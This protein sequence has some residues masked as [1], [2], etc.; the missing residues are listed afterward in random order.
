MDKGQVLKLRPPMARPWPL[1]NK[2]GQL[3][4]SFDFQAIPAERVGP[5]S[6]GPV[7]SARESPCAR[8]KDG[9]VQVRLSEMFA[10]CPS[11]FAGSEW[12]RAFVHLGIPIKANG[13]WGAFPH[14]LLSSCW[15]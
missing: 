8:A 9:E 7:L 11:L 4:A 14:S 5:K 12:D 1:G 3:F 15:S 6:T 13:S 10:P 2:H